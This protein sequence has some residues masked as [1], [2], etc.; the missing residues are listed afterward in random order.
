MRAARS[1]NRS[2]NPGKCRDCAASTASSINSLAWPFNACDSTRIELRGAN[3]RG[4]FGMAL[5]LGIFGRDACLRL[6]LTT[7]TLYQ[8]TGLSQSESITCRHA[9][10]ESTIILVVSGA[11]RLSV[12]P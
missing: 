3:V 2:R 5:A 1:A 10:A 8:A 9:V 7:A 12:S 11:R 6:N 4:D